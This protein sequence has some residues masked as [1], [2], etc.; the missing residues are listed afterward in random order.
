VQPFQY[1]IVVCTQQKAENVT[2]CAT[3]GAASV[4]EAIYRELGSAG[5]SENVIVSGCGCLGLCDSGPL[6]IIYPEGTW[7]VKVAPADVKEIVSSHIAQGRPVARLQR[8]DYASMRDEV[9]DHRKKYFAMVQAKDAAGVLPDDLFETIRAFMPSR[10]ILT[11]LELDVF[12]ALGDGCTSADLATRLATDPRATE[13]LLDALV[14]LGLLHKQNG[15]FSNTATAARFLAEG[16]QDSARQA[17]LHTVNMWKRWS[18]LTDCVKTGLPAP[19]VSSGE[20]VDTFIA[21][22]DHSARARVRS[23]VQAVG[24]NG[25]RRMLDLGGGSGVYS[26]AFA[27]AAPELHS[28]ILDLPE[29]TP[30][31]LEHAKSAGLSDRITVR[32]GDMLTAELPKQSYDLVLLSSICHMFPPEENRTLF[33]RAY[34]AL[35]PK[36]RIAIADFI[37]DPDKASPRSATLFALNMLVA[38][39]AGATYSEPEYD[40]WLKASGF[41]D[42][43]RVR[44]PGPINLIVATRD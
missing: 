28:E 4:L 5:L 12:T 30:I 37:V 41:S 23:I 15:F 11:A 19:R 3:G 43:K 6:M 34:E 27:K 21:A 42:V 44:I 17:Q 32:P 18:Q 40:S 39:R 10:V 25:T 14:S 8:N 29:I 9:L 2:C 20:Y 36:G 24:V 1:H 13:M 31:A 35:A 16:T 38:T 26:I 33:A 7:Y 22:M